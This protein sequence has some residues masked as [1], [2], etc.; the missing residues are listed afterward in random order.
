MSLL[1]PLFVSPLLQSP[2]PAKVGRASGQILGVKNRPSLIVCSFSLQAYADLGVSICSL[3]NP[4]HVVSYFRCFFCL[5]LFCHFR[6]S[7]FASGDNSFRFQAYMQ[8][9]S[10]FGFFNCQTYTVLNAYSSFL[11][12]SF[13]NK[14]PSSHSVALFVF[15]FMC[16][17][18]C[19]CGS[20]IGGSLFL[21]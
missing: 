6:F 19:V 15:F 20:S 17:K 16:T 10:I 8:H 4:A 2:R 18:R 7:P 9:P 14:S 12:T 21:I 5:H 1:L 13:G 11:R 3:L